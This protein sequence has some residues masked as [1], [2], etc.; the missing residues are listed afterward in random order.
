MELL[1]RTKHKID[2]SFFKHDKKKQNKTKKIFACIIISFITL[3]VV[4]GG[5]HSYDVNKIS[6]ED[7]SKN[8]DIFEYF[9]DFKNIVK[10]DSTNEAM[11]KFSQIKNHNDSI[12]DSLA[13]GVILNMY[14]SLNARKMPNYAKDEDGYAKLSPKDVK[15][16]SAIYEKNWD[17]G[18]KKEMASLTNYLKCNPINLACNLIFDKENSVNKTLESKLMKDKITLY[19]VQHVDQYIDWYDKLSNNANAEPDP[20][21]KFYQN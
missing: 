1:K 21:S 16:F 10:N 19:N 14:Q 20:G 15:E 8:R 9:R 17:S 12:S 4:L 18:Y 3:Q 11:F 13:G 2:F 7:N 5:I 6:T